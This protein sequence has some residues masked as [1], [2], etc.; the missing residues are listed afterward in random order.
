[1]LPT[2]EALSG[3]AVYRLPAGG[4]SFKLSRS[5][6]GSGSGSHPHSDTVVLDRQPL[7]WG[8]F[9]S[10]SVTGLFD[11]P[12]HDDM[13]TLW[14]KGPTVVDLST[15]AVLSGGGKASMWGDTSASGPGRAIVTHAVLMALA[16]G[17][18]FPAAA[19]VARH[20]R[21][22]PG[23]W[24]A[25][26]FPVGGS[27]WFKAHL[28][29]VTT[30]LVAVCVAFGVI[31][32]HVGGSGAP[33]FEGTHQQLGLLTCILLLLQ[34]LN[35][36]LRPPKAKHGEANTGVR[37]AWEFGHKWLGRLLVVLACGL[38]VTTGLAEMGRD[39]ASH[40]AVSGGQ[41][42][43]VLWCVAGLGGVTAALEAAR[44]QKRAE[45]RVSAAAA[46]SAGVGNAG[47]AL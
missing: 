40:G 5:R 17:L 44:K 41:A 2:G 34:P 38:V 26:L 30:A 1:M 28:V 14:S 9:P 22:P 29:L 19:L 13:H 8:C 25:S 3:T 16:W 33:H 45:A 31:Y 46:A 39:G 15:G 20:G 32:S 4:L 7:V 23:A 27:A 24:A 47:N 11:H 21:D 18:L 12:L 10:W 35:G 43:W 37:K 6:E 42:A 36:L